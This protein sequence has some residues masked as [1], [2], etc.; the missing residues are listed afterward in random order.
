MDNSLDVTS[1]FYL[2]CYLV[3][4]VVFTQKTFKAMNGLLCADVPL[5]NYA[6]THSLTNG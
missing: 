6:L 5:R 2:F 3:Y 1:Y 4:T